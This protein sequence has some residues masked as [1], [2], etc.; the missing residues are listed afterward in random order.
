[1]L[2]SQT[3]ERS[4]H[5]AFALRIA[6]PF[7]FLLLLWAYTFANFKNYQIFEI[8]MFV[9]LTVCYVYYTFYMIYHGFNSSFINPV[10]KNFDNFKF[11]NLLENMNVA[12]RN[13]GVKTII[14]FVDK[15]NF[16]DEIMKTGIDY[17][18]GFCIDKP[19]LSL[20]D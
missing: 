2:Y 12:A 3:K 15:S 16:Y 19:K 17:V 11:R 20:K 7:I 10:S 1:M 5:F 8:S 4:N 6:T 9:L 18:Q 14:R 13:L